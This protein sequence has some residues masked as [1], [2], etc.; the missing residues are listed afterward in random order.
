[1]LF[2][3]HMDEELPMTFTDHE[4]LFQPFIDQIKIIATHC[5]EKKVSQKAKRSLLPSQITSCPVSAL[6]WLQAAATSDF[7]LKP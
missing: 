3:L 1:M 6:Q 2:L 7:P 5:G 4:A